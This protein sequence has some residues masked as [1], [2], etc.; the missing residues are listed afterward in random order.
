MDREKVIN[1]SYD[2]LENEEINLVWKIE[3]YN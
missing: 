3:L 1:G 2:Y